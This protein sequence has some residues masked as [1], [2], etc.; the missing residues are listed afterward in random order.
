MELLGTFLDII[1]LNVE[2]GS[3]SRQSG[4]ILTRKKRPMI[5][6]NLGTD[7]ADSNASFVLQEIKSF[8]YLSASFQ[9]DQSSFPVLLKTYF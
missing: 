2:S 3:Y 7:L 1:Y 4:K 5:K 8:H 6:E 9:K